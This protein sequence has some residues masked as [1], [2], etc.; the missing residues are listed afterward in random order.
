MVTTITGRNVKRYR[1]LRELS[2][3]KLA[4]EANISIETIRKI[5]RGDGNVTARVLQRLANALQ[6]SIC[7]LFE[8]MDLAQKCWDMADVPENVKREAIKHCL[9]FYEVMLEI[10]SRK[11]REDFLQEKEE[12]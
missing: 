3:E 10:Y 7:S 8:G 12:P 9:H 2:Q 6:V 11:N 4:E 5:E 1:D